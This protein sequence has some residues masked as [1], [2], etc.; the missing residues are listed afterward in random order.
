M[1]SLKMVQWDR[2]MQGLCKTLKIQ[3]LVFNV[4]INSAFIGGNNLYLDILS[5]VR[6]SLLNW[7]GRVNRTDGKRNL[8]V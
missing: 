6:T 8:S 2:N 3:I 7:V 4:L 5:F 1:C